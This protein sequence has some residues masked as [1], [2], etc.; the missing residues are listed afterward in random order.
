MENFQLILMKNILGFSLQSFA[1]VLGIYTFNR[2][3]II[4]KD[5]MLT[6][7]IVTILSYIMKSLPISIG[8]QTII[9]MLFAYLICVISLKRACKIF[10][11]N[12]I[13]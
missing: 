6:S 12:S 3:K 13:K 5:Y 1:M 9:N 10:C 11:V 2:Q 4:L 8:V 7:I